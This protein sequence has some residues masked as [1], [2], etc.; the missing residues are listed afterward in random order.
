MLILN[1]KSKKELR[2]QIGRHLDYTETSMFGP[3]YKSDG[4]IVGS[5]RPQTTNNEGREFFA[6]VTLK[7]N[8]IKKVN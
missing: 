1:Y 2:E 6:E 8:L 5:N 3:E 7:N 4:V